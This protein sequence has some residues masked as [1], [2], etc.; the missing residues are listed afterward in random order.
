MSSLTS[1]KQSMVV[2]QC[3]QDLKTTARCSSIKSLQDLYAT[4]IMMSVNQ[5]ILLLPASK[6]FASHTYWVEEIGGEISEYY[7]RLA[8]DPKYQHPSLCTKC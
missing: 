3:I 5:S 2:R 1:C 8:N 4:T 6:L 7:Q